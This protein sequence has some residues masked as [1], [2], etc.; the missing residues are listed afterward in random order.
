MKHE[1]IAKELRHKRS[2]TLFDLKLPYQWA[3]YSPTPSLAYLVNEESIRFRKFTNRWNG[4]FVKSRDGANFDE[5][6]DKP[7]L[8]EDNFNKKPLD[9]NT[10]RIKEETKSEQHSNKNSASNR[11]KTRHKGRHSKHHAIEIEENVDGRSWN[12]ESV[13]RKNKV[14]RVKVKHSKQKHRRHNS[15]PKQPVSENIEYFYHLVGS[16][17]LNKSSKQKRHLGD[18]TPTFYFKNEKPIDPIKKGK[19]PKSSN[20]VALS[21][22][23][24]L[25]LN[26]DNSPNKY[27][28]KVHYKIEEM[29]AIRKNLHAQ[30]F[31]LFGHIHQQLF[32]NA[33]KNCSSYVQVDLFSEFSITDF[34]GVLD[35]PLGQ[36]ILY[37]NMIELNESNFQETLERI[38]R[39]LDEYT[40]TYQSLAMYSVMH[41]REKDKIELVI[42][43]QSLNSKVHWELNDEI[44]SYCSMDYPR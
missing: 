34:G 13:S 5:K 8:T 14:P 30:N 40:M 21:M 18:D 15:I 39:I 41:G 11:H 31:V 19:S 43:D 20:N 27:T 16:Q 36:V 33:I 22:S 44:M 7:F 23:K 24:M 28:P 6:Q 9:T 37:F 35:N 1:T 2:N 12:S 3:K 25:N 32:I 26:Y 17:N 42:N 29:D 4:N 38:K 10:V